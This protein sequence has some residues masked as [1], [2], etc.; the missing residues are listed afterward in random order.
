MRISVNSRL[1][2]IGLIAMG[3]YV[4][5]FGQLYKS[6]YISHVVFIWIFLSNIEEIT[7]LV[8]RGAYG[9]FCTVISI[10]AIPGLLRAPF[11]DDPNAA[12]TT[13]V[14][15]AYLLFVVT[16]SFIYITQKN[17]Y[18]AIDVIGMF[19]F[20]S[21]I[22]VISLFVLELLGYNLSGGNFLTIPLGKDGVE[23]FAGRYGIGNPNSHAILMVM[24][25]VFVLSCAKKITLKLQIYI[26]VIIISI[27]LTFSRGAYIM[28]LVSVGF[29]WI[30]TL[31]GN[32]NIVLKNSLGVFTIYSLIILFAF[33]L[34]HS[35]NED[36]SNYLSLDRIIEAERTFED[37]KS[38]A[39]RVSLLEHGINGIFE[40]FLF[41]IGFGQ[42]QTYISE[43]IPH[44]F[45]IL[46]T[47]ENGVFS[48][49]IL[50]FASV[51]YL[52]KSLIA[53][54]SQ[55]NFYIVFGSVGF[56]LWTFTS[57][58][59]Y[60]PGFALMYGLPYIFSNRMYYNKPS[61]MAIKAS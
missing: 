17:I 44:V 29:G 46:W 54:K 21:S 7:K 45:I 55:N 39:G 40:N 34:L 56:L 27:L 61:E 20:A 13:I 4:L 8:F 25:T 47:L 28:L 30:A 24:S 57:T 41:G 50:L 19:A 10:A 52:H 42:A 23:G 60:Y 2:L 18:R 9:D 11:T 38:A 14:Q 36:L 31:I 48:A 15:F 33:Y 26:A 22:V 49:I 1:C 6:I 53:S 59:T 37:E 58:Y 3:F 5:Q 12:I 35:Y 32:K 51:L 16:P 43:E